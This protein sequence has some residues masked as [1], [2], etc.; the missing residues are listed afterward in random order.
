MILFACTKE[1]YTRRERGTNMYRELVNYLRCNPAN[2]YSIDDAER[3]ARKVLEISEHEVGSTPIVRIANNIGFATFK[4]K[5]MQKDISGNIFV[6]GT[7]KDIY[8]ANEVI[9]VDEN[10]NYAHQRFIIAHE[11]GH[12]LMDYLGSEDSNYPGRLF[13]R[14]YPKYNHDSLE[15]IRADRFAAELLMPTKLFRRL[16]SRAMDAS[17]GDL[18]YTISFLAKYFKTKRSSV[19]RRIDEVIYNNCLLYN[20]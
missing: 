16:Y 4:E 6:G 1:P 20:T 7:T 10:E 2:N 14:A 18:T 11:L 9:V 17:D 19:K 12:Y 3:L 8:G 15:E 5:N 13:S